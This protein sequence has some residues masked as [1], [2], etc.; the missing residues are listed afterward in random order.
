MLWTTLVVM[1]GLLWGFLLPAT[2]QQACVPTMTDKTTYTIAWSPPAVP[3]LG[4]TLVGY[5]LERRLNGGAWVTL[6]MLLPPVTSLNET[7]MAVG[8]YDYQVRAQY[9]LAN[10]TLALSAYANH[11]TPPPCVTLVVMGAPSNVQLRMD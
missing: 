6:P 7:G 10:G 3:A 4:M 5:L 1:V 8:T 11:G 2:A 9:R